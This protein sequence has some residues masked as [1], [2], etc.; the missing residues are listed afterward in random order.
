MTP[1]PDCIDVWA[2]VT[3]PEYQGYKAIYQIVKKNP[4]DSFDDLVTTLEHNGLVVLNCPK[5]KT[6]PAHPQVRVRLYVD[7]S[8]CSTTLIEDRWGQFLWSDPSRCAFAPPVAIL[9][10]V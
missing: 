3:P 10:C 6:A 7:P 2:R 4:A 1:H 8:V 5:G 9:Q